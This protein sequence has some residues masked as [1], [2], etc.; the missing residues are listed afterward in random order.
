MA[1]LFVPQQY[2]NIQAALDA[3]APQGDTILVEPGTY[4]GPLRI[5]KSVTIN[6]HWLGGTG[7]VRLYPGI[8][9][10]QNVDEF[11]ALISIVGGTHT[12]RLVGI[13][14]HHGRIQGPLPNLLQP[15]TPGTILHLDSVEFHDTR[16]PPQTFVPAPRRARH[17][18]GNFRFGLVSS[19]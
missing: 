10:H 5:N 17:R 8:S 12:I 3:A 16:V 19:L 6:G 1:I 2:Q 7:T 11:R 4:Y 9:L 14:I 13:H 15:V 18:Q